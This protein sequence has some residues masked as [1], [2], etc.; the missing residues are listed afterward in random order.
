M[1]FTVTKYT[2]YFCPDCRGD[3]TNCPSC[4]LVF[5]QCTNSELHTVVLLF[6]FLN[7]LQL[8]VTTL[9][10]CCSTDSFLPA[11]LLK[12][13]LQGS[14]DLYHIVFF[15]YCDSEVVGLH[16]FLQESPVVPILTP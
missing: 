10:Q 4:L 2:N 14:A 13:Y 16:E 6:W 11:F 3:V 5:T 15:Y 7:E 12:A 1:S 8:R 9:S